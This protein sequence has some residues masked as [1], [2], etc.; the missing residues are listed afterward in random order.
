[1]CKY[2]YFTINESFVSYSYYIISLI[3][4]WKKMIVEVEDFKNNQIR[5]IEYNFYK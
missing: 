2:L 4:F 5:Y 1:M 3:I